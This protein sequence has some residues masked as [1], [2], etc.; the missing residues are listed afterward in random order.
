[1]EQNKTRIIDIR[2]HSEL[3]MSRSSSGLIVKGYKTIGDR[4]CC[5]DVIKIQAMRNKTDFVGL[6]DGHSGVEAAKYAKDHLCKVMQEDE[7]IYSRDP[8]KVSNAIESAF[9]KTHESM[10]N[11]RG[12]NSL[13][14]PTRRHKIPVLFLW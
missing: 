13:Y 9:I 4:S 6:F 8:V 7:D 2:S 5:E 1:M 12:K 3:P 10:W 11:V 14:Q